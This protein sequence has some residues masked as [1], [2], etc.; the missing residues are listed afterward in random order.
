MPHKDTDIELTSLRRV[1]LRDGA[2]RLLALE[3]ATDDERRYAESILALLARVEE[4]RL[5]GEEWE[6]HVRQLGFDHDAAVARLETG[7]KLRDR[8]IASLQDRVAMLE[9]RVEALRDELRTWRIN[10]I[11]TDFGGTSEALGRVWALADAPDVVDVQTPKGMERAEVVWP[12]ALLD[13]LFET[14]NASRGGEA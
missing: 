1:E 9:H 13:A 5:E 6:L 14:Y 8:E 10:S 7:V 11:L 2:R 4:L 3:S 12:H